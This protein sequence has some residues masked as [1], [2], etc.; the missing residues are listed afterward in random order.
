[1]NKKTR[2]KLIEIAKGLN[3]DAHAAKVANDNDAYYLAIGKMLGILTAFEY[4][5]IGSEQERKELQEE[6][7]R[8]EKMIRDG[9]G[10]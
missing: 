6:Q 1:M 4:D 10:D 5:L 3:K 9:K 2:D 8:L 7:E